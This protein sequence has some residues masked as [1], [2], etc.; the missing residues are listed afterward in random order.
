M[1]RVEDQAGIS[2]SYDAAVQS[3]ASHTSCSMSSPMRALEG[4]TPIG[5]L[6]WWSGDCRICQRRNHG[7]REEQIDRHHTG[8]PWRQQPSL[9]ICPRLAVP[10]V[11]RQTNA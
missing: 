11:V 5:G 6:I 10:P 9:S 2:Q 7:A 1:P 8:R 4:N 3:P